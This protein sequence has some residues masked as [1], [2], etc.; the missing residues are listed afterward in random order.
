MKITKGK[1]ALF[2]IMT[3]I[4]AA[5]SIFAFVYYFGETYNSFYTNANTEVKIPG[6]EEGFVPQGMEYEST[7]DIFLISGYM[8]DGSASRLYVVGDDVKYVTFN[9]AEEEY[10]GHAGGVTTNGDGV[11]IVGDGTLNYIKLAEILS[12]DNETQLTFA[13]QFTAPN[14]ADFVTTYNNNLLVGEFQRDGNYIRNESHEITTPSD[15][16]N[17]AVTFA[18]E[19]NNNNEFGLESTTPIYAISTPSLVQGMVVTDENIIL[20][21]S[22]SLPSS[23]LYIY[24]NIIGTTGTEYVVKR[25][26]FINDG[27]TETPIEVDT[28]ILDTPTS[29]ETLPPMSEEITLKDDAVCVLFENACSKYKMF[30]RVNLEN[31]YNYELS[32]LL[33]Q[34]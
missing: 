27:E 29:S 34:D 6:L 17:K 31:V 3:I 22:Y 14:G 11:W 33:P 28:Y 32:L 8:A 10:V 4:F 5:F 18:Y 23:H 19:I 20:S 7:N 21:T 25:E 12:A 1:F 16:T 2:V 30:T 13:S 26:Y 24:D 15:N 9:Y